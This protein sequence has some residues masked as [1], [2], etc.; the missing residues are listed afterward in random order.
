[1][2]LVRSLNRLDIFSSPIMGCS[3]LQGSHL[4][5]LYPLVVS[6][7]TGGKLS[8]NVLFILPCPPYLRIPIIVSIFSGSRGKRTCRRVNEGK[9]RSWK[10]AFLY[11]FT[12]GLQNKLFDQCFH[13]SD[14]SLLKGQIKRFLSFVLI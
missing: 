5:S 2:D 11:C 10:S 12:D 6:I 7:I 1:M 14:S 4:F 8:V 3:R 13:N 9:S